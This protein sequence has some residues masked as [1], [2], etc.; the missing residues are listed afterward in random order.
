MPAIGLTKP[1][2]EH[3]L[4]LLHFCSKEQLDIIMERSMKENEKRDNQRSTER[5]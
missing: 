5:V 3:I 1:Q 4:G 2:F